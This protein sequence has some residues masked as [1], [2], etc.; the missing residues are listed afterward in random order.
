MLWHREA[1]T[2]A[3]VEPLYIGG[4][5]RR[6]EDLN[7]TANTD[8]NHATPSLSRR[9]FIA[10]ASLTATGMLA[11]SLAGCA[12]QSSQTGHS[13]DL[14][15]TGEGDA[16]EAV[17][18]DPVEVINAD[19]VIVGGGPAGIGA[20]LEALDANANVV[21]IE[22]TEQIGGMAFGTEGVF[23]YDSKMQRDANVKLPTV[24]EIVQE[25]LDY[26]NYRV[27][28]NLWR[29]FVMQS[30]GTIDWLM[31]HGIKFDR[32]DTYQGAS[33]FESFHWWPGGNGADFGP[34]M[35]EYLDG[36]EGLDI[37]LKTQ[38]LDLVVEN[39]TVTGVYAQRKNGDI[40]QVNGKGVV[41]CTGGFSQDKELMTE[42][43]GIDWS[44]SGGFVTPATGDGYRMMKKAGAATGSVCFI[45]TLCVQTPEGTQD[46]VPINIGASY[47]CLPV[48]NQNGERF[49]AE[50]TFAKYF[51]ML[52]LNA[53]STQEHTWT[54]FDQ[55][56]INRLENEGVQYGFVTYKPGDKLEGLQDQLEQFA[57]CDTVKKG[58]T[59]EAL[60]KEIGAD[61]A[62]LETTVE[63]WN[64]FCETGVD[65]DFGAGSEVL[66]PIGEGPY[67]AVHSDRFISA[68]I[69][70]IKVN[71]SNQVIDDGGNPIKGLYSAGVDSCCL[72]KETYNIQLSGGMQAYNFYSGRNSARH[73][74]G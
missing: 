43:S 42:L 40:I 51:A 6:R 24:L 49:M 9:S 67:Y 29:D 2:I 38:A 50:D 35:I 27:D 22:K 23:G 74:L 61:A 1:A 44:N 31:D 17:N 60:A 46:L 71:R 69:G 26:T 55:N 36:K 28:A 64:G 58:E 65:E 20:T 45:N 37:L 73:I 8:A 56:C 68:T 34:I 70:G 52:T 72:Y 11:A 47:Q 41:V 66:F 32:V 59:L 19:I 39:E 25:E 57:G 48:V 63:R 54:L 10:T 16:E 13:A 18:Y 30:G 14:S 7:M 21:L 5:K 4:A 3:I 15:Q 62:T 12:P 53:L 33:F